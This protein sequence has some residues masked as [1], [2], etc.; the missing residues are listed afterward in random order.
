[1]MLD[2]RI[3]GVIVAL[4]LVSIAHYK[5]RERADLALTALD[6]NDI[7]TPLSVHYLCLALGHLRDTEGK[8]T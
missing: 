1:M 6:Y 7:M 4:R 8:R 2:Q 3:L 5:L